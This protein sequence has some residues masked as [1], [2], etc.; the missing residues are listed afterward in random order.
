[1]S[2]AFLSGTSFGDMTHDM[3]QR[4]LLQA[5][6]G[7][8]DMTD[9]LLRNVYG[10][11]P[12]MRSHADTLARYVKRC[13]AK[14]CSYWCLYVASRCRDAAARQKSSQRLCREIACLQITPSEA[15]LKGHIQFTQDA[16]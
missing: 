13:A 10:G 1:M 12:S 3:A 7:E 16:L 6:K 15:V 4:S 9:A 5:L 8:A 14:F 11:D 2:L